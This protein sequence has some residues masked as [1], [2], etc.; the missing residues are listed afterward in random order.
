M[1]AG[2]Y[3]KAARDIAINNWKKG[4]LYNWKTMR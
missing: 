2:T 4:N 3:S 1:G